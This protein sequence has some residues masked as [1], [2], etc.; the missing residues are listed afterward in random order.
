MFFAID[1]IIELK[2]KNYLVQNVV[3]IENEIYYNVKEIDKE[4]NE[5]HTEEL[6]VKALND[7]GKLF[8]EEIIDNNLNS[9][10]KERL[11]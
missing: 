10:I 3:M 7:S 8:I 5:I 2:E 4:T 11:T 9:T 6:I 1:D